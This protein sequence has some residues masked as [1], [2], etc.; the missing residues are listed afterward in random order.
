MLTNKKKWRYA[1]GMFGCTY[2]ILAQ[3]TTSIAS[4]ACVVGVLV[5]LALAALPHI[6]LLLWCRVVACKH[7]WRRLQALV[8]IACK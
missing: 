4:V 7:V 6:L 8:V 5:L 2:G 3:H 1:Y